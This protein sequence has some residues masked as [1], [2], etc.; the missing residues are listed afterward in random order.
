MTDFYSP[1][2]HLSL[3]FPI[4]GNTYFK[5]ILWA[6][7]YSVGKYEQDAPAS[8]GVY[9]DIQWNFFNS[10]IFRGCIYTSFF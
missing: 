6:Y 4:G 3:N 9:F 10:Q 2:Y 7:I 1:I 8:R 5:T